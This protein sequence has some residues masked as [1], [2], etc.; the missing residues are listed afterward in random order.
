MISRSAAVIRPTLLSI[1]LSR[2]IA[3]PLFSDQRCIPGYGCRA[4]PVSP[5]HPFN[6]AWHSTASRFSSGRANTSAAKN[7]V[8]DQPSHPISVFH[9]YSGKFILGQVGKTLESPIADPRLEQTE[10][11]LPLLLVRAE[12][13]VHVPR[14]SIR[15]VLS[16]V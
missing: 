14:L 10:V 12:I 2:P 8:M 3:R 15:L 7:A 9:D 11:P 4:D 1:D 16:I 13:F 6:G 5:V